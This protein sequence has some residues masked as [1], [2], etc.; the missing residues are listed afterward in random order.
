MGGGLGATGVWGERFAPHSFLAK[1]PPDSGST[2][3]AVELGW[4]GLLIFCTLVFVILKEAINNYFFIQD[5]ELKSYCLGMTLIIFAYMIGNYPQEALVQFPSNIYFFLVTALISITKKLDSEKR[6][7]TN[8][9]SQM[10]LELI[11]ESEN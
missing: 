7:T 1:F 3:V 6:L 2:R 8:D 5:P 9:K 4:I 11:K 10:S